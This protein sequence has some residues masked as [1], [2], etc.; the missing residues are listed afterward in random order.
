MADSDLPFI[1]ALYAS[2]R[3]DEVAATG[4]PV[5]LQQAFLA[6]QHRAQHQHYRARHPCA[7]WLIV[8]R[9]GEAIGRL[10][11]EEREA[12][13]HVI[14]ISLLP[15]SRGQGIGGAILRDI[16]AA[17][18][19]AGK[20]VAMHVEARNPARRLYDRLGFTVVED[21]GLYLQLE[22]RRRDRS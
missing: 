11:L 2:T 13:L 5:P 12:D 15:D 22:R 20:A 6:Q 10:Y 17:A 1:A 7:E 16:I 4:W 14:D 18:G 21:K 8:E 19:R 9:G 3:A